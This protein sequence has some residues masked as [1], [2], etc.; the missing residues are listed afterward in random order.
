MR[1]MQRGRCVATWIVAASLLAGASPGIAEGAP[2]AP[3]ARIEARLRA[4]LDAAAPDE[5]V[6]VGV[7]LR[8]ADLPDDA[9]E[10]A[11]ALMLREPRSEQWMGNELFS[12]LS[13]RIG[14][15]QDQGELS[16]R[17][18]PDEM[19]RIVMTALF[20]FIVIEGNASQMRRD[21]AH[22]MLDLLIGNHED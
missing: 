19:T 10:K 7:V 22:R 4:R 11:F 2:S 12:Y 21:D 8:R 16:R 9:P 15:A 13:H 1:S 17:A 6:K 18:T 20:G 5:L 3:R 14:E